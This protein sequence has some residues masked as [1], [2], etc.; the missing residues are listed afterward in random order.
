MNNRMY[1]FLAALLS[2]FLCLNTTFV[3]LVAESEGDPSQ[4][5]DPAADIVEKA[6]PEETAD[7]EETVEPEETLDPTEEQP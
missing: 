3:P 5:E 7:P 1:R 4:S 6:S 2:L